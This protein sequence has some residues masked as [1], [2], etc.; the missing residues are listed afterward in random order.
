MTG[1]TRFAT[2]WVEKGEIQAPL[3]VMRFD[4]SIFNILG[5][6]LLGL[7]SEREMILDTSTYDER[8]TNSAY[9]PGALVDKF[10]FTL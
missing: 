4:D 7:S 5:A 6:N 1:M 3:Q 9:L 2:F 10:R 8:S